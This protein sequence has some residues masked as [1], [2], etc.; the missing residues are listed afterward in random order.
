MILLTLKEVPVKIT[1]EKLDQLEAMTKAATPGPWFHDVDSP[2]AMG[3]GSVYTLSS[4]VE[5]GTIAQPADDPYPRG[6]YSPKDD[7]AFIAACRTAVPALI[8]EVRQL[9]EMK[10]NVHQISI[11]AIDEIEKRYR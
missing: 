3:A 2:E 7:M 9:R 4:G 1:D 6:K 11:A 10:K 5:G 8:K